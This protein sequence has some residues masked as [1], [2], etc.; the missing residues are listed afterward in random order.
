MGYDLFRRVRAARITPSSR[1]FVLGNMA[2]YAADSGDGIFPSLGT[3]GADCGVSR[4]QARRHVHALLDAGVL[5]LVKPATQRRTPEYRIN[6]TVLDA[7]PRSAPEVASTQPLNAARGGADATS[8]FAQGL[9]PCSLEVAPMQSRGGTHA[10]RV[11]RGTKKTTSLAGGGKSPRLSPGLGE[12]QIPAHGSRD[13]WR[14]LAQV[15]SIRPGDWE[16]WTAAAQAH[17]A[18]NG[19]VDAA[20]QQLIDNPGWRELSFV[21]RSAHT[22]FREKQYQEAL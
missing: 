1:K 10:T 14:Q 4:D 13:L 21:K 22:G 9:H 11:P 3:I 12:N 7:L 6:V 8:G 18:R 16:R 2:L 19:D 20:I 15:R 5:E 17:A